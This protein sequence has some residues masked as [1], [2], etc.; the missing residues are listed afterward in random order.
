[1]SNMIAYLFPGQGAQ[2]KGMGAALFP[3]YPELTQKAN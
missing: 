3:R 2:H 1:M